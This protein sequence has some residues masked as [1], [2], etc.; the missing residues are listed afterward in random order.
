[1]INQLEKGDKVVVRRYGT[2]DTVDTIVRVTKTLA[3]GEYRKY[4][5]ELSPR[6][7]IKI[8]GSNDF[9]TTV[10]R[11]ATDKDIIFYNKQTAINNIIKLAGIFDNLQDNSDLSLEK[12]QKAEAILKDA[13][14][15]IRD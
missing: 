6:N 2:I 14:Q 15:E 11:L 8:V 1:M 3:I 13:L 4:K 10:A 12:L 9:A 5:R 7:T